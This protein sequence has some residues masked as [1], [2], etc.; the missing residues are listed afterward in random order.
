MTPQPN[1]EKNL[2]TQAQKGDADAFGELYKLHLDAIY[3]YIAKRVSNIDETENLTQTVFLKAWPAIKRYQAAKVPFR[4]WLYRIAHNAVIDHYRTKKELASLEEKEEQTGEIGLI[5]ANSPQPEDVLISKEQGRSLRQAIAKL[6][7]NYQQ[8]LSL[9]FLNG[10]G[11]DETAT[12]MES[13][14]NAIRV[15]QFRALKALHKIVGNERM[16]E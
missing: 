13:K 7:P 14:V 2:I 5:A 10:L 9:R 15:L 12:V 1:N 8:V 3:A 11:Y 4:A 16:G 6:K